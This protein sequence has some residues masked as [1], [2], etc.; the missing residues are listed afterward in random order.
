M[1]VFYILALGNPDEQYEKS[2]HN[3]GW[4]AVQQALKR[5]KAQELKEDKKLKALKTEM[6]FGKDKAVVIFPLTYMNK[7]GQSVK[8]LVTSKKKAQNLIVVHDDLDLPIGKF[9][10]SKGKSSGG[11]KGVESVIRAVKTKDFIRIRVGISPATPK[12]KLKKPDKK[13]ILDFIIGDFKPKEL[14]KVKAVAKKI[15]DALEMIIQEGA[16]KAMSIYNT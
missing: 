10:I 8:P 2:R 15:T 11:H 16:D 7:S 13:K 14:Q 9:K 5:W 1:A 4:I 6:K 12:G 3:A